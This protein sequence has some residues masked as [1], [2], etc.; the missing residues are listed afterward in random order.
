MKEQ[1]DKFYSKVKEQKQNIAIGILGLILAINFFVPNMGDKI[2]EA[3]DKA[4]ATVEKLELPKQEVKAE[5]KAPIL[6]KVANCEPVVLS[7]DDISE[8][9]NLFLAPLS[10]YT[11]T[12][13]TV[14]TSAHTDEKMFMVSRELVS[15]E[16]GKPQIYLSIAE[17]IDKL[18]YNKDV[19]L[20][21]ED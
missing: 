15:K 9:I 13:T 19:P 7:N 6:N 20:P 2:S 5:K 17:P 8:Q 11:I 21:K 18:K 14:F 4:K 1:W 3:V 12:R 16:T 10:S